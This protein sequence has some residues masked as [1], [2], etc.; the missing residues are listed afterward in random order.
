M[1]YFL[2]LL[3]FPVLSASDCGKKKKNADQPGTGKD[4]L[5]A[6]VRELIT[7]AEQEE[8]P[9]PPV[10]VDAYLYRGKTVYLFTMDCCDFFNTVYDDSCRV[11]C[12]PSGG[13]TGRGDGQC[14][15]FADSARLI[16]TVWQAGKK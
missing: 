8:P 6:C 14:P 3:L 15:G 10:Q 16:Q 7:K 5:P 2:F 1:K 4:S 13:I 11:I 9:N 12:A